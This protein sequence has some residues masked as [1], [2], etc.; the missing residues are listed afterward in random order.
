MHILSPLR[1]NWR[2]FLNILWAF[3][4]VNRQKGFFP[5]LTR[6][7]KIDVMCF[8]I[9]IFMVRNSLKACFWIKTDFL[10]KKPWNAVSLL[11]G[12]ENKAERVPKETINEW[13]HLLYRLL[14]YWRPNGNYISTIF[15]KRILHTTYFFSLY[16]LISRMRLEWK[17]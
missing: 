13:I 10:I 11:H 9:I 17:M 8:T 3:L 1:S 2:K 7:I 6:K 15:C 14:L 16:F 5:Q 12:N 4:F